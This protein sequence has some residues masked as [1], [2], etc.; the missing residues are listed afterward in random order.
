[1]HILRCVSERSVSGRKHGKTDG[2]IY[3]YIH[4]RMSDC[5]YHCR[6]ICITTSMKDKPTTPL[7]SL[8]LDITLMTA[9]YASAGCNFLL[10]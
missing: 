3:V 9:S 10:W 1:M 4:T 2:L 8:C 6:F 7:N 5:I